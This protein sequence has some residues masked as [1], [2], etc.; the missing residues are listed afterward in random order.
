MTDDL[1]FPFF[2]FDRYRHIELEAG[3]IL[4]GQLYVDAAN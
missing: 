3:F 4:A 2:M 1:V